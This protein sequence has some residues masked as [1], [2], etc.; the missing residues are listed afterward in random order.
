MLSVASTGGKG[1]AA[2]AWA[3]V[4]LAKGSVWRRPMRALISAIASY[5]AA[6]TRKIDT[7]NA[8]DWRHIE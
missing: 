1:P 4:L 6:M 7:R 2:D 5:R 8:L 3:A